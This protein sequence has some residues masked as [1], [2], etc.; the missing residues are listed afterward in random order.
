M[1]KKLNFKDRNQRKKCWFLTVFFTTVS[2]L[3]FF[4]TWLF[5][6]V[7]PDCFSVSIIFLIV[8]WQYY[9]INKFFI[10]SEVSNKI[11]IKSA[12]CSLFFLL[13]LSL[14]F[15]IL[16]KKSYPHYFDVPAKIVTFEVIPFVFLIPVTKFF[17]TYLNMDLVERKLTFL[18]WFYTAV[19]SSFVGFF[20]NFAFSRLEF[21]IISPL[22]IEV[23]CIL[24]FLSLVH[25]FDKLT[26]LN[27]KEQ[28]KRL[29]NNLLIL[30][31]FIGLSVIFYFWIV[32]VF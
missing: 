32:N 4:F 12:L 18:Y 6:E 10:T 2:M 8:F 20:L 29:G 24:Y 19:F 15:V 5:C 9:I 31:I 1:S 25:T 22:I 21:T 28:A 7:N 30:L 26:L 16:G 11:K 23:L 27:K 17:I 13:L 3:I 14:I